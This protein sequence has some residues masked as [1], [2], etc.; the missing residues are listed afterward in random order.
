[1][2]GTSWVTFVANTKARAQDVNNN[3]DWIEGTFLPMNAGSET[4]NVYDLGST[5]YK[6]RDLHIGRYAY[7]DA[8]IVLSSSSKINFDGTL[9]GDTYIYEQAT[10]I[11]TIMAG[12]TTYMQLRA[13]DGAVAVRNSDFVVEYGKKIF[14]DGT[15]GVGNDMYLIATDTNTLGFVVDGTYSAYIY[16]T[17]VVIPSTNKLYLDGGGDTYITHDISDRI[18]FAVGGGNRV[19][20]YDTQLLC[21]VS[22]IPT[23]TGTQDLGS[24]TLYWN[25]FHYRTATSHSLQNPT[26]SNTTAELKKINDF[27]DKKQFPTEIYIPANTTTASEGIAIN[28][29]LAY[30]LK[31]IQEL[32]ARIE[33][34]ESS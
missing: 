28:K 16:P 17:S 27:A 25:E 4:N 2:A 32:N 30:M 21:Q 10:D 14:L 33:T 13:T 18:T 12:S 29:L 23:P 11:L 19:F 5:L 22:V 20:C 9:T 26:K 34:L 8:G 7:I 1:M 6:W 3:F 31:S 15:G 24:P